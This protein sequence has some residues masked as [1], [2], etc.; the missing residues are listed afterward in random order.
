MSFEH[1]QS[2]PILRVPE[3]DATVLISGY[4]LTALISPDHQSLLRLTLGVPHP[5]CQFL[6]AVVTDIKNCDVPIDI[7]G[8]QIICCEPT[9]DWGW[10]VLR[11]YPILVQINTPGKTSN[12]DLLVSLYRRY[13]FRL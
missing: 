3:S 10:L 12:T 4:Y 11:G 9:L 7:G 13:Y 5:L 6:L 2:G 1:V 8:H